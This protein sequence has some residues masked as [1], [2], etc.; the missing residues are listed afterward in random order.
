MSSTCDII[1]GSQARRL[2]NEGMCPSNIDQITYEQLTNPVIIDCGKDIDCYNESTITRMYKENPRHKEYEPFSKG[3]WSSSARSKLDSLTG[4]TSSSSPV[5]NITSPYAFQSSPSFFSPSRRFDVSLA[6][7][8][9]FDELRSYQPRSYVPDNIDIFNAV[10][11]GL[12]DNVYSYVNRPRINLN[13]RDRAGNTPLITALLDNNNKAS[14]LL[15]IKGANVNTSNNAGLTPLM[16][17]ASNNN[18]LMVD[19]LLKKGANRSARTINGM[20]ASDFT[21]DPDIKLL[22][23][24]TTTRKSSK[25]R[26]K[27]SRRR[28]KSSKRSS[29]KKPCRADQVRNRETGRCRKR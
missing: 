27:S 17:A 16:A 5:F 22:I 20:T 13:P 6:R 2:E 29:S 14:A 26:S 9:L 4:S 18:E 10:K 15:I 3:K 19:V 21:T 28:S 11:G 8:N 7:R 12:F 1:T 23:Q 24:R 25:R